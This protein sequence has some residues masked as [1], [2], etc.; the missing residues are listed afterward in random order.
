MFY[1]PCSKLNTKNSDCSQR[2]PTRIS[3]EARAVLSGTSLQQQQGQSGPCHRSCNHIASRLLDLL[4]YSNHSNTPIRNYKFSYIVKKNVTGLSLMNIN[5]NCRG[6][7][8][9]CSFSS[10]DLMNFLMF[11]FNL[12]RGHHCTHFACQP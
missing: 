1:C 11:I 12:F 3:A 4:L 9:C 10:F 6:T 8:K 5:R 7:D 2:T